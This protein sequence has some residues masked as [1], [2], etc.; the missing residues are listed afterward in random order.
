MSII[1]ATIIRPPDTVPRQ[2]P[3]AGLSENVFHIVPPVER[4][5]HTYAAAALGVCIYNPAA[6]SRCSQVFIYRRP[7]LPLR[8]S[9]ANTGRRYLPV[10]RR[11]IKM[12]RRCWSDSVALSQSVFEAGIRCVRVFLRFHVNL[13]SERTH[14]QCINAIILFFATARCDWSHFSKV[15]VD[16]CSLHARSLCGLQ[17][18]DNLV[19][20]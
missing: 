10:R 8:T 20:P 4:L 13:S 6:R 11:C 17:F 19:S 15:P 3:S 2:N 18:R 16:A 9:R 7:Y 14:D 5:G 12:R 1:Y